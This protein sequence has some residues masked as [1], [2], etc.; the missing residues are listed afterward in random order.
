MIRLFVLFISFV[1][2]S[3]AFSPYDFNETNEINETINSTTTE[4]IKEKTIFLSYE[5]SP[6]KIYIGEVFAI[7]VKAIIA[8]ED[9]EEITSEF[10]NNENMDVI[11]K[12]AKWQW[13]SD[14]IFYNTFYM[15]VND[16]TSRLPDIR[17]NIFL[18]DIKIDSSL[19]KA[20]NPNIIKLNGTNLYSNVIAKS[21][22]IK[23]YKTSQFD[24]KSLIIVLE[25][26]AEQSN[27][28]NFHL[29]DVIRDGIDSSVENLPF[30]KIFYYAIIPNYQ[31]KFEFTYFNSLTNK[32]EKFSLP[33]VIADDSISTQIDLNPA[34]SSLQIY[35]DSA[36]A[37]VAVALIL[38]FLRRKK[39]TYIVLL[40]LLIGLLVYD[41]NPLNSIKIESNTNIKILPT[42]KSTIFYTT[43]RTLYAQVLDKK[44]KYIKILLPNGKIGWI[45]DS[46]N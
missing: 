23:K 3:F 18:D 34:Q 13:F 17:L 1:T 25:I 11:N 8:N 45:D 22:K 15:K 44:N 27:L 35:K 20:P 36:Y 37:I 14:N 31:K 39:I 42:Q 10:I 43:N 4:T 46:E 7:K 38:L 9:F 32:F 29:K 33:I 16:V 26:E 30:Y 40:T 21:L 28:S 24:D 41:K 5:K 6:K 19:L 12:D 2:F